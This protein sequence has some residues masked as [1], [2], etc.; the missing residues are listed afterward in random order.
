MISE[1][2]QSNGNKNSTKNL[3]A[4]MPLNKSLKYTPSWMKSKTNMNR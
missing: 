2:W 1:Y 3:N 4:I